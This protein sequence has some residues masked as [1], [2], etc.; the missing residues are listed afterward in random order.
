MAATL[1]RPFLK[2]G[3]IST[4]L[5]YAQRCYSELTILPLCAHQCP[6]AMLPRV[7]HVGQRFLTLSAVQGPVHP[8][9]VASTLSEY[10]AS[11]VLAKHAQR[12]ALIARQE[13]PRTH[14]GPKSNNLG[15]ES[16]LAWD[17]E[18]FDRHIGA[19]ARGLLG[20]G[21]NKGD[22]IGV[23]MGNNRLLRLVS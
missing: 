17:F 4:P 1:P 3:A 10:F 18:E 22:R 14:G 12:P 9:L 16:H 19:L 2:R 6:S 23:I 11:E 7:T 20:M 8:P 21:V 13:R 15:V 5:Y